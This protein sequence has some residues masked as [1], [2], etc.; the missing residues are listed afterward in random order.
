MLQSINSDEMCIVHERHWD[1]IT[2]W[3]PVFTVCCLGDYVIPSS[4]TH[5]LTATGSLTPDHCDGF[6][7]RTIDA[8][9][10]E[11]SPDSAKVGTFLIDLF[12]DGY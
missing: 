12:S 4:L 11:D 5:N 2:T 10:D 1:S 7:F 3:Y 8:C 6:V 9:T